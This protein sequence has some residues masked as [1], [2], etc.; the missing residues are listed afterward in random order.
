MSAALHLLASRRGPGPPRLQS[1]GSSREPPP[2]RG[3]WLGQAA[4]TRG[5]LCSHKPAARMPGRGSAGETQ[6]KILCPRLWAQPS[7]HLIAA[8]L[9][10]TGSDGAPPTE[11]AGATLNQTRPGA[12]T[13]TSTSHSP[14]GPVQAT[15]RGPELDCLFAQPSPSWSL[16]PLLT[17]A[18]G[19]GVA[20][21]AHAEPPEPLVAQVPRVAILHPEVSR[22]G[23]DEKDQA[24]HCTQQPASHQGVHGWQL[25]GP[26]GWGALSPALGQEEMGPPRR[27]PGRE[28]PL[29]GLCGSHV[30]C[31]SRHAELG[32]SL[33]QELQ[34]QGLWLDFKGGRIILFRYLR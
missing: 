14:F 10:G 6:Q 5:Q 23:N 18:D 22:C 9:P 7:G 4:A 3:W 30:Y 31:P 28:L 16:S 21:A 26:A 27:R 2:I 33:L 29:A 8:S 13:C 12:P 20:L 24:R 17:N 25:A 15:S 34:S 11:P 32:N 19:V 1:T